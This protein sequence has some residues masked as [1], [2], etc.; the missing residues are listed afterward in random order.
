MRPLL[1]VDSDRLPHH[2][3]G[4]PQ[5]RRPAEL[6]SDEVDLLPVNRSTAGDLLLQ[7]LFV[8]SRFLFKLPPPA[9]TAAEGEIPLPAEPV[10]ILGIKTLKRGMLDRE[11]LEQLNHR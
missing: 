1:F 5:I 10:V 8:G 11:P 9:S 4:L 7:A 6:G 3:C 2:L